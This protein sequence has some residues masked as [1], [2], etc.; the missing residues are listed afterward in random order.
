M[1]KVLVCPIGLVLLMIVGQSCSRTAVVMALQGDDWNNKQ[2]ILVKGANEHKPHEKSDFAGFTTTYV[3]RGWTVPGNRGGTLGIAGSRI[4]I[5]EL[6]KIISLQE[7]SS[8]HKMQFGMVDKNGITSDVF[9]LNK[10]YNKHVQVGTNENSLFN[11]TSGFLGLGGEVQ[12]TYAV[13]LDMEDGQWFLLLDNIATQ[14]NPKGYA[15][16]LQKNEREYFTLTPVNT[17]MGKNGQ[18]VMLPFGSIGY[19]IKDKN[20]I[21]V[22]A[23]SRAGTPYIYFNHNTKEEDKFLLANVSLAIFLEE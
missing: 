21:A 9:C 16:I 5:G 6:A 17:L 4:Y 3:K 10:K 14:K 8:R 22:A 7:S 1:K 12:N 19:E 15:G 20:G 18:P 2:Q 23:I 13:T 11:I